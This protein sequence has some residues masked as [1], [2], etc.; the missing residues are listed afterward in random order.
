MNNNTR[1][2]FSSSL[3]SARTQRALSALNSNEG[4]QELSVKN[5]ML[6]QMNKELKERLKAIK[7]ENNLLLQENSHL[8]MSNTSATSLNNKDNAT[9]QICKDIEEDIK[10]IREYSTTEESPH[11]NVRLSAKEII[12]VEQGWN[13]IKEASYFINPL[14]QGF[15]VEERRAL[16]STDKEYSELTEAMRRDILRR[17]SSQEQEIDDDVL[18]ETQ[19]SV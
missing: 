12:S 19:L 14:K 11:L 17:E 5:R 15:N 4:L 1:L 10:S 3:Q 6:R 13:Y 16:T 8:T 2:N 18:I 7:E 9:K